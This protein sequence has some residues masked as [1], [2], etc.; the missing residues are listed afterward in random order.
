MNLSQALENFSEENASSIVSMMETLDTPVALDEFLQQ[1]GMTALDGEQLADGQLS[2]QQM[3]ALNGEQQ[4]TIPDTE[5]IV[6]SVTVTRESDIPAETA[7]AVEYAADT[8]KTALA[9]PVEISDVTEAAETDT[10]TEPVIVQADETAGDTEQDS[11]QEDLAQESL[12]EVDVLR[13][14]PSET[15]QTTAPLFAEQ[16]NVL[17]G[18]VTNVQSPELSS[19]TRMQQMVDIV[20]QVSE[21]LRSTVSADTT[22]MEMQLNP[23]SLG[24][25]YLSVV[26]K[27]GVMTASFQVQSEEARQALE[28]QMYSLRETLEAKNL[29]V[30]AVDVQVSDFSFTQS[31]EAQKEN[32]ENLTKQGKRRFRY[33]DNETEDEKSVEEVSAESVRRQVMRDTG[34]SI[35]FTA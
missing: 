13:S 1:Q 24:K 2:E 7:V 35:D 4:M 8:Q 31:N 33:D 30:E 19:M 9:E 25:V 17:Q 16:F 23:E 21:Q 12:E 11:S 5:S 28:S 34:G 3:N 22:T 32:Q 15:E 6:E 20:N 14:S 26:S 18:D 29:K 27:A 10:K